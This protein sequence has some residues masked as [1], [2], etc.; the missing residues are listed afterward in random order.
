[1]VSSAKES[2][3]ARQPVTE[4]EAVNVEP[5]LRI[6]LVCDFLE[7]QWPSMD[8]VADMLFNHLQADHSDWF[9]AT[10]IRPSMR[11]RFTSQKSEVRSQKSEV[12]GQRSEFE[13]KRFNADRFLNRFWDYPRFVRGLKSK[14]DLFHLIDH[15]YSQLL[16][17]L[18][19][20]RTIVTCHDLDTFQCLVN[21]AAEPR[22]V[23]FR[24][25]MS[26][27]LSGFRQAA[28]VA[29]V[30]NATRDEL[31]AH[32]LVK[33]ER[34]V[35]IPN[36]VHP[37]CSPEAHKVADDE[38]TRLLGAAE[39]DAV[40]ILH[41][42]TTIPRKRIDLLL[43]IFAAVQKEYPSARLIRVGGS[44]TPEQTKLA[45]EL[46]VAGAIV[47]LP[48]LERNL[49]AAVYRRAAVV[50]Q[51]SEREGF[52]LPVVEAMACGT[53]VVASDLPVLREVGGEAALY[54]GVGDIA[55]WAETV[56]AL[57]VERAG[58]TRAWTERREAGIAQASKFSWAEYTR[59]M[60]DLYREILVGQNSEFRIQNSE[61]RG[62]EGRRQSAAGRKQK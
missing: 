60:V 14:F 22:S 40:D 34:A 62:A 46:G 26:R 7:E 61:V 55:S 5:R 41:V 33:P 13:G 23:F 32:K 3:T 12:R 58:K 4:R 43:R 19:P 28:R 1:M 9:K 30:S 8:L 17:E 39:K 42:G 47:V 15:S 37:S 35:V 53:M 16:H 24:K 2:M 18:P 49:L 52:G 57:M 59:K 6:A 45:A 56:S 48:R 21:P 10:R 38:V 29:C 50:L 25:M 51:P 44:F 31:L 36:G 27:T 11:R 20:E 54:C